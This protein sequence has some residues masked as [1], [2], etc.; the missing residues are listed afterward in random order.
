MERVNYH[1]HTKLCRH[2]EGEERDY[3]NSAVCCGLTELGF[4]DHA[5]F[6]DGRYGLRMEYAEMP[7]YIETIRELKEEFREKISIRCGLEIEYDPMESAYYE[8]LLTHFGMEYL[9]LGQHYYRDES[10]REL[11]TFLLDK[12]EDTSVYPLYA[13]SLA[14]GMKTGY[15]KIAAHPDLFFINHLP[16][17]INCERACDIIVDAAVSCG[18]ILEF[19]ANGIR[20]GL[21]KYSDGLRYPYP[22][23]MFWEKVKNAG[24]PVLVNS[25]CHNPKFI[26]DDAVEKA[27]SLAEEWGLTVRGKLDFS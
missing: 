21:Q 16:A 13:R 10:G 23:R 20:R 24:I 6:R 19:N 9:V 26:W 14:E 18:I 15:F 5:P 11:N 8:E 7:G 3:V 25:D 17:D 12:T 4:S 27:Y 1:T 22:H 2:A